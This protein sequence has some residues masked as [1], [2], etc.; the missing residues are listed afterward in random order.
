[1][2]NFC[3][4][5]L[6]VRPRVLTILQVHIEVKKGR[7]ILAEVK[8]WSHNFQKKRKTLFFWPFYTPQKN[9]LALFEFKN[10]LHWTQAVA[11]TNLYAHFLYAAV[12]MAQFPKE[13]LPDL[14]LQ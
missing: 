9:A 5:K 1:M 12:A 11:G 2:T 10:H 3:L 13:Y 4:L 6:K 7:K 8:D 14:I